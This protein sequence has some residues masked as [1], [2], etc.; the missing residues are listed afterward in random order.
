MND[1][2]HFYNVIFSDFVSRGFGRVWM[3][4]VIS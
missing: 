3:Y 2:L 1:F 4:D